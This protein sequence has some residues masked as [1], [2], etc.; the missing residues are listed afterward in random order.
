MREELSGGENRAEGNFTVPEFLE[1]AIE[2]DQKILSI[3]F[4]HGP[5]DAVRAKIPAELNLLK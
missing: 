5:F 3:P 4:P 1:F 2:A